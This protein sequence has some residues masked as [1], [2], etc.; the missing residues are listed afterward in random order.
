MK[1][2]YYVIHVLAGAKTRYSPL[3]KNIF[4]LIISTRKLKPYFQAHPVTILTTVRLWQVM[5]KTNLTGRMT[6]WVMYSLNALY[7]HKL[8][9]T[10]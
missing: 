3:E 4:T 10:L 1:P 7:R 5:H 8:W 2:I 6:K 9:R